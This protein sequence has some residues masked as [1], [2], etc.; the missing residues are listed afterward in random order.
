M[1][2]HHYKL[3]ITTKGPVHIG[4]GSKYGKKDYFDNNGKIAI[5]DVKKFVS[6]LNEEQI[7]TYCKFLESQDKLENFLNRNNDVYKI[8]K[9]SIAYQL[10][11]PFSRARRGDVQYHDVWEFIKDSNGN[12]YVPASGIKGVLRT[13]ILLNVLLKKPQLRDE[14]DKSD[15]HKGKNACK[16]TEEIVF[17]V[18]RPKS[19]DPYTVNDIMKYISVTDSEPLSTADL[20][21]VK[22]YDK[23]SKDDPVDHKLDMGN[24][25]VQSGNE[26]NIYRE[27]LRPNTHFTMDISVDDKLNE[28][29]APLKFDKCGIEGI[30]KESFDFYN[31]NFLSH[32]DVEDGAAS[33]NKD[34]KSSSNDKC[35]YIIQAGPLAGKQ[36]RNQ[37]INGTGYCN[38]HQDQVNTGVDSDAALTSTNELICYVG[39]GVDFISKTVIAAMFENDDERLREISH[40][41]YS[42][43]K[44]KANYDMHR[45]LVN[46]VI[47][48][49]FDKP[50]DF[51]PK[52]NRNGRLLK[53]KEDHRHWRDPELGVSPHTMK[54]GIIG[55]DKYP[56]GKCSISIKEI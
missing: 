21:F 48:A 12:P 50:I 18:E 9:E 53:A 36:C 40:F 45:K 25:T 47:N 1:T 14:F 27:S 16:D 29:L 35:R 43:F 44:T 38:T 52:Y 4:N 8:A 56:M 46:E 19:D 15:L 7:N 20:V 26:L 3:D 37:A 54:Y 32:F 30:L 22:K 28:Y 24:L 2:V 13:A 33:E 34:G 10:D 42:Q 55:K 41:L 51:K 39:G 23:F 5:L 49:G 11:S 6:V 31:N 17:K